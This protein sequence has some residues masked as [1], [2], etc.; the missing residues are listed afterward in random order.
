MLEQKLLK[1]TDFF[2]LLLLLPKYSIIADGFTIE[3]T[4]PT[5]ALYGAIIRLSYNQIPTVI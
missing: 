5:A 2:T 4:M 3:F 1:T